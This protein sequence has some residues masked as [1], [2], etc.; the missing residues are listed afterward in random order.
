M[1]RQR[2]HRSGHFGAEGVVIGNRIHCADMECILCVERK[3]GNDAGGRRAAGTPAAVVDF[4]LVIFRSG[5]FI[6]G[7]LNDSASHT[8]SSQVG[9]GGRACEASRSD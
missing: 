6:P 7:E 5:R 4:D 3:P 9:R 8:S 1:R 2:S